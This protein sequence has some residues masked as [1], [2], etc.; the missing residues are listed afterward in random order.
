MQDG[1]YLCFILI[2]RITAL[3]YTT[4]DGLLAIFTGSIAVF[5]L[6]RYLIY[7]EA[8]FEGFRPAET[9]ETLHRWG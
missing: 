5:N 8:D 9:G 2:F 1:D 4:L 6:R 7:S 3:A